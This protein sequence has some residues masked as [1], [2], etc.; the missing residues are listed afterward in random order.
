M[1]LNTG[2]DNS[3]TLGVRYS[4]YYTGYFDG[5]IDEVY[6]YSS[7][8]D[9]TSIQVLYAAV[10]AAPTYCHTYDG[11]DWVFYFDGTVVHTETV[12]L[13]TGSDNSLTL[14]VRNSGGL[15][16]YL[17]GSIDEVY[18]YSSALDAASIQVLYAAVTAAPTVTPLP[19]HVSH[20]TLVAY[21]SFDDG[22]AA[23]DSDSSR[24]GTISGATATTG[25]Y[26]VGGALSFDGTDDY[27][28]FPSA[29]TA[30]ILGSAARTVCLWAR[31]E[32]WGTGTLFSYDSN[33]SGERFGFMTESTAG[34]FILLGY[35]SGYDS[36]DI[37]ASGSDDGDWHQYCHTYDGTDWVFY[38]DGTVVHTETVALDTGSDNSLTLGVLYAAVTAA[39]TVTPLP[40][41]VS[42]STLVA[43]YSFDD[44]TAADDYGSLDGTIHGATATTGRDGSGALS[45]DGT[46][47][48]VELPSAVTADIQGSSSRTVCLWAAID[49]FSSDGGLFDYGSY[50][51]YENFALQVHGTSASLKVQLWGADTDVALSGSDDGGW[52]HYCLTYDGSAWYLYFDGS[53][54][55]TAT[56]AVNTGSDYSPASGNGRGLPDGSIDDAC[57]TRPRRR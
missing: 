12:A 37:A 6:V 22:T 36:R 48:Y 31:L 38:F 23:E 46:D 55:A 27:V 1:A 2:S 42:H 7:A 39:P 34:E 10:T 33:E 54:A 15:S 43:H 14:G 56:V 49:S 51:N 44:G 3:L 35:G 32:E 20:S 19:T 30:D 52:H 18:V 17:D 13:D 41:H 28:E 8:L 11:T 45:F 25:Q 40:T 21:Y 24:D 9:E 4:G 50:S 47:D 26:G 57:R 5:S 16:G 53:Q 29:V